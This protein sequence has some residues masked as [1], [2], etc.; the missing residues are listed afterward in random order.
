[1]AT[2]AP[3]HAALMDR[4]Y[5]WQRPI[6]D[7]TRKYYLF[8]RDRLID[9]LDAKPGMAVLEIGCGTGRNLAHVG[10]TW[11][12]VKLFGLDISSEMLRAARKTLGTNGTLALG[13]ATRFDA[14]AL[15]GR[16]GFE[17]VMLSYAV[18]MIPDWQAALAQAAATLAPRGRL[19]VVDFGDCSGLPGPLRK[20]LLGWLARFHVTP[21][22]DL[23]DVAGRVAHEQGL[24]LEVWRGPLGYY[25]MVRLSRT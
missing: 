14:A 4:I 20:L 10:R 18:S 21:R 3:D 16:E 23:A 2:L 17:R 5:R 1:M 7:L 25:Q 19:H 15:L 11:R 22:L 6:Y 12:G 8:G 13:D 9:E 24:E